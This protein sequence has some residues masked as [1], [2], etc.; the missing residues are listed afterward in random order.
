MK[1]LKKIAIIL[2]CGLLPMKAGSQGTP[3]IDLSAIMATIAG[4]VESVETATKSGVELANQLEVLKKTYDEMKELKEVYDKIDA[5]VYNMQEVADIVKTSTEFIKTTSDI[6]KNAVNS[7]VYDPREL[8]FLLN[9]LTSYTKEVATLT[10]RV[11]AILDPKIFKWDN[12]KRVEGID[13]S[14]AAMARIK[15]ALKDVGNRVKKQ[16]ETR[17]EVDYL[18]EKGAV[19]S[20][21]AAYLKLAKLTGGLP[22]GLDFT[23]LLMKAAENE[24]KI[25]AT[26]EETSSSRMKGV[27]GKVAPLFWALTA[28]IFLFG[29]FKVVRKAQAQED[30]GKAISIWVTAVLLLLIFGQ[31]Y[32]TIFS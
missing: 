12:A 31:L 20:L 7:R 25:E 24:K 32:T 9:Q 29:L 2:L 28:F 22:A 17:K 8:A 16:T 11:S 30:V 18:I 5:Y 13:E 27:S 4:F 26:T 15:E 3:V 10:Q 1:K 21:E 19:S 6:Y 14:R 23:Y